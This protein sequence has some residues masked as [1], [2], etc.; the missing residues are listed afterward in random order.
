MLEWLRT[1][2]AA[3]TAEIIITLSIRRD[4]DSRNKWP[5]RPR[6]GCPSLPA[7]HSWRSGMRG[8]QTKKINRDEIR[9]DKK[10][11]GARDSG[12]ERD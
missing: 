4:D 10:S 1:T 2:S 8:L 7:L 5:E 9:K 12:K 11:T 6:G 3:R